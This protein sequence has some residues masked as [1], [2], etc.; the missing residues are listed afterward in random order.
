MKEKFS[1]GMTGVAG[2]YAVAM[3][4]SKL[5]I[6]STLTLRNTKGIDILASNHDGSRTVSIQVKTSRNKDKKWLL[7]KKSETQFSP[8]FFYVFVNIDLKGTDLA[9]HIVPSEVVSKFII[10]NHHDWVSS[11]GKNGRIR[12]DSTLRVFMDPESKYLNCWDNLGLE[13][14]DQEQ[15]MLQL[16]RV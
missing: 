7:S 9:F 14:P 4:L 12:N 3:E 8:N 10:Q 6:I 2:E 16:K 13:I 15:L 1:N 5:G 11:P